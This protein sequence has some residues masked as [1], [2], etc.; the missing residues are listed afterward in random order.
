[1][2]EYSDIVR[3][4]LQDAA[5]SLSSAMYNLNTSNTHVNVEWI[6]EC[7]QTQVTTAHEQEIT[8]VFVL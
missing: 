5:L 2:T 6:R 4:K 7:S 3:T 8:L 1:M